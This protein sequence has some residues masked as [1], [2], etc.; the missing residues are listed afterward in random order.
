MPR[1]FLSRL[2]SIISLLTWSGVL[3]Y[4]YFSGRLNHYLVSAYRPLVVI[5]GFVMLGLAITL[6]AGLRRSRGTV[7]PALFPP[8]E[9]SATRGGMR[10]F[11][12]ILA[13][14]I[15]VLPVATAVAVSS[16]SFGIGVVKNRGLVMDGSNLPGARAS[17]SAP[18]SLA[19]TEP[20]LP[21]QS[22]ADPAAG[23]NNPGSSATTLDPS[24]YLQTTPE[25]HL[26]VTVFDLLMAAPDDALR[27]DFEGRTVELVGQFLPDTRKGATGDRFNLVRMYMVC[28]AADARP[29]AVSVEPPKADASGTAAAGAAS[30][31]K[32]S[33]M[34]WVKIVGKVSFPVENGV[35]TS[36]VRA[37]SITP[38]DPP[39]EVMLY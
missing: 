26:I 8:D 23:D 39:A 12:Q 3:L 14:C 31:Y 19:A 4:F 36:I 32:P 37:A 33:D 22:P 20:P 21:G 5:A 7:E 11:T 17:A 18:V 24:Q 10:V 15:L 13:F 6:I 35:R 34:A 16:D 29:I 2:L 27:P 1:S 25:G 28:C 30:V 38:S 9:F